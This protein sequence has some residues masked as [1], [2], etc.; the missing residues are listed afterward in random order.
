MS[1]KQSQPRHYLITLKSGR[2]HVT[3]A[4]DN[5]GAVLRWINTGAA[6]ILYQNEHVRIFPDDVAS[7]N[8]IEDD[9]DRQTETTNSPT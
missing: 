3:E 6:S 8:P 9:D 7:I 5:D 2:K 1:D 4:F